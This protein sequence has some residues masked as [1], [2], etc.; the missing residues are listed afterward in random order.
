[1][2]FEEIMQEITSGFTGDSDKDLAYLKEQAEKYKDHEM[3][4]EI[5][6][7]C[8][9]LMYEHLPDDKK[10]DIG[11]YINNDV[12]SWYSILEEARFNHF[13]NNKEKA[14]ALIESLVKRIEDMTDS[15]MFANDAVSEYYCF[16]GPMETTLYFVNTGVQKTLRAPDRF[17][18]ATVYLFYGSLLIDFDRI[19]DAQAALKKAVRWNPANAEIS[20][21]Y[22]ETY[23]MKGEFED[24]FKLSLDIFKYAYTPQDLARCY[25]NIG[26]YFIEKK[27]W[28]EAM[29]CYILSLEFKRDSK[30]A[31]S[32]LY[33]INQM[34]NGKV[35]EPSID[36]IK[37]TAEK[38]GFPVGADNNVL[39][40][41]FTLGKEFAEQ[42]NFAGAKHF[43]GIVYELTNDED[44]KNMIAALPDS[45]DK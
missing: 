4:K 39:G 27:L 8:G 35:K 20:F 24:Y 31:Q 7:A 6:R 15:G 22:A 23:K 3:S 33:Y 28:Q 42:N 37:A 45:N 12:E 5:L 44:I 19:D 41:A 14:L 40:V 11:Q 21:E 30:N 26:F 13:Q 34:T 10:A 1:M 36:F 9:R 38:Y 29:G 16:N 18:F 32:E 2:S 17:P 43:F 25:R